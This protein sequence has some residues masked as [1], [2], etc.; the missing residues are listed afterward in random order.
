MHLAANPIPLGLWITLQDFPQKLVRPGSS[1]VVSLPSFFVHLLGL[2]ELHLVV[3][4][5]LLG[6]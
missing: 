4:L 1:F 6:T 2:A 5:V 3:L